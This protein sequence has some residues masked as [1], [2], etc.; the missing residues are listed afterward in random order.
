MHPLYF[1]L[2]AGKLGQFQA[3]TL[4]QQVWLQT[5][6]PVSLPGSQHS[7]E[8]KVHFLSKV[9]I[10]FMVFMAKSPKVLMHLGTH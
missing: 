6:F 4:V 1:V 8:T 5:E 2:P 10:T 3:F 9:T 7:P